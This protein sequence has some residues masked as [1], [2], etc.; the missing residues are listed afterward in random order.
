MSK[1]SAKYF[2]FRISKRVATT[3]FFRIMYTLTINLRILLLSVKS[4]SLQYRKRS[5]SFT[6]LSL[7]LLKIKR[8]KNYQ[9]TLTRGLSNKLGSTR[10]ENF[11]EPLKKI[12][13]MS[14]TSVKGKLIE[15]PIFCAKYSKSE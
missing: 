9:P 1:M 5:L 4:P 8:K 14:L 15:N 6:F 3:V 13:K 2:I 7:E 11:K 10:N 12:K